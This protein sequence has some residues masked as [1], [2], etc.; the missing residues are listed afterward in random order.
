MN[1]KLM[2]AT[3]VIVAAVGLASTVA[4][5]SLAE[6]QAF[7]KK[8]EANNH[9]SDQGDAHQSCTGALHSRG[10]YIICI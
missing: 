9:I 6:H 1:T 5:G 2:L 4:V 7:A 3:L 10:G 8:G